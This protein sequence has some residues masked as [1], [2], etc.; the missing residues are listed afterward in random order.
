MHF[1]M[2]SADLYPAIANA[3]EDIRQAILK[4]A[5]E[6]KNVLLVAA[7]GASIAICWISIFTIPAM[8]HCW[9]RTMCW[10]M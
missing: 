1:Q 3:H 8:P 9:R 10:S 4:A 2:A 6:Q 5:V 7:T